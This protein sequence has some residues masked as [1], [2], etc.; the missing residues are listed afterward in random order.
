VTWSLIHGESLAVLPTIASDSIDA[1]IT[2]P[3]YSS[4]GQSSQA[5]SAEPAKKYQNSGT[6]RTYPTFT[7]DNRD[8]RSWAFWS[9]MWLTEALRIAKTGAPIVVFTD[10]R[11][12]P[13]TT[14]VLQAA[15]WVWR[16]IAVWD[17]TGAARPQ[18]GRF[19]NQAEYL[20]WGSK[21]PMPADRPVG[22][23][24][25]V[26]SHPTLSSYRGRTERRRVG[27]LPG[28]FR[29]VVRQADKFHLTGKP[30]ALMEEIVPICAAGGTILDPFAGSGTTGVAAVKHGY[31][32]IGIEREL[33]YAQIARGRIADALPT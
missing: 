12:L 27:A 29:H 23:L 32:F 24:P 19:T 18:K 30:T 14:D 9:V 7:G 26:F 1:V 25:G 16:G 31:R 3:P 11:Q 33:A 8:Q 28:V 2:D 13:L 6:A 22:V 21:G 15:G 10:W 17:K 4:G 20:V 5:R